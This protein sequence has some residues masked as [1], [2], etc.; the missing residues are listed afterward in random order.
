MPIAELLFLERDREQA[1]LSAV[2]GELRAGRPA[3]VTV[4]GEPGAGQ[5]ELL[6]WAA[7]HAAE[8]GLRVLTA[9]ATP[10][11]QDLRYGAVSQL[12]AGHESFAGH[13]PHLFLDQGRPGRFPGL[14]RLLT[15]A[16]DR[17]I[18]LTVEDVHRLD[19]DSLRWLEALVRRLPRAPLAL[20]TSSIRTADIGL[21]WCAGSPLTGS[22]TT[23]ELPLS[24][25]T[26]AGTDSAVRTVCGTLGDRSFLDALA[27]AT[28][29]N[30]AAV[31]DTLHRFTRAGH[32]PDA[33][34]VDHVRA[35]AADVIGEHAASALG[36]LRDPVALGVLRALAVC[37][38][39][40]DF[41]LVL[42]LAGP[43]AVSEGRLRAALLDSGLV[44]VRDGR[45]RVRGP[46]VRAR[47]IEE[48]TAAERA[49]LHARAAELA[50]RAAAD[51]QGIG[52][53]LLPAR[54]VGAP[55][56]AETLCRAAAA[57]LRAGRHDRAAAYLSRA[58]DEPLSAQDRLGVLLQL[59]GTEL[60]IAP[61]AAGRRITGILREP[62]E[63]AA[64]FRSR[65]G[66]LFLLSG[67]TDTARRALAGALADSRSGDRRGTPPADHRAAETAAAHHEELTALLRVAQPL[68]RTPAEIAVPPVPE[69]PRTSRNPAVNGVHA[70]EAAVRGDDRGEARRLARAAL[71]P[72]P[73]GRPPLTVPRLLACR[74]LL[75]TE[76]GEE[77]ENHLC[78]L[79]AEA[80]RE[81]NSVAVGRVLALRA[82][83]HL[84]HGRP[85]SAARDLAAADLELP[86][87][88]RHPLSYPYWTA[89]GVI[90]DLANGHLDRA[91]AAADHPVPPPAEESLNGAQLLFARG[92]LA[93]ADGDPHR[94]RA[95]FRACGR[96]L[97]Q[98][99]CANPAV[100]PWRS[101]AA[102]AAHALGDAAQARRLA[103]EELEL[104]ERWGAP[105]SIGAARLCLATISDEGRVQPLRSAVGASGR[106]QGPGAHPYAAVAPLPAGSGERDRARAVVP[107]TGDTTGVG[108]G[109]AG[110]HGVAV[111]PP[112]PSPR[113]TRARTGALP[114]AWRTLSP[115]EQ[116]AA[117][118]AA[119]GLANREIA[120]A[121]S[122]TTRTVELRLSSVYR[123]LRIRG[124]DGLRILGQGTEDD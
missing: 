48:M 30:P 94:A 101:R 17:P 36:G 41:P 16:R 82:E 111:P 25:L 23:V 51:D 57:A 83:L 90:T 86:P 95:L 9:R 46:V 59:A 22:A 45:I 72:G 49:D 61:V 67:D 92:L 65:A 5:N 73:F 78:A 56:V 6:R 113:P 96:W 70:W 60:V 88:S 120:A 19:S 44:V 21:D 27:D 118:L 108:T 40:L 38:E 121:L 15:V 119:R 7:R 105:G 2:T 43:G 97:L 91:R 93:N 116:A 106:S 18:L 64:A 114:S 24:G 69:L 47:I 77:A 76:D 89:L 4:T 26:R 39:L 54:P 87:D 112:L 34:H 79:L 14:T 32:T 52:D 53:L 68:H 75:L 80:H 28:G 117:A 84:R 110:A 74:T 58:L 63:A 55:W 122:V 8:Q 1:V 107:L 33:D 31:R 35:I 124:R 20:I 42:A 10:A 102:E 50:H 12:L 103:Q 123:K 104:A 37:D 62:G 13:L 109:S 100:L 71:A 85:D 66:D 3:V 11:E 29:G 98:Y 99:G 81:R 115:G